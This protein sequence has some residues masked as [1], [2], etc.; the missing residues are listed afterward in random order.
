M[1]GI[2]GCCKQVRSNW[3]DIRILFG[4]PCNK[5]IVSFSQRRDSRRQLRS[6]C[7]RISSVLG[8]NN[9][10]LSWSAMAYLMELYAVPYSRNR[11]MDK[12]D[13][14][15]SAELIPPDPSTP[16]FVHDFRRRIS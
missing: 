14:G 2:A 6:G 5:G 3:C 15:R 9:T 11:G 8:G 10:V 4:L 13:A 1:R 16:K 7:T 12:D